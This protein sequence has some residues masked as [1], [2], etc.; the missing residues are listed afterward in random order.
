MINEIEVL[1][2]IL[3]RLQALELIQ[4]PTYKKISRELQERA[5][6]TSYVQYADLFYKQIK[7]AYGQLKTKKAGA[8]TR[9]GSKTNPAGASIRGSLSKSQDPPRKTRGR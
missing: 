2:A 6:E 9:G 8:S 1:K 5:L 3:A 7:K 4:A